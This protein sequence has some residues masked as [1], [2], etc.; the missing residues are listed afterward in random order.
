MDDNK[1]T[2]DGFELSGGAA[3]AGGKGKRAARPF[4]KILSILLT[5]AMI[6][7]TVPGFTM[8]AWAADGGTINLSTVPSGNLTYDDWTFSYATNVYTILDGA[9]VTVTGANAS[10]RRL[11]VAA[12][13]AANI[14]LNGVTITG[15]STSSPLLLNNGAN[16]TLVLADGTTNTLTGGGYYAGIHAPNGT[17][18]TIEG[19]GTL[20]ATGDTDAAGIG[21]SAFNGEEAG[22]I[23]INGGTVIATGGSD[24][25]TG[26]GGAIMSWSNGGTITING[27]TVIAT[28]GGGGR[29]I[30]RGPNGYDGSVTINGGSVKAANNNIQPQPKNGAGDNVYLTTLTVSS[31]PIVDNAAIAAAAISTTPYGVNGVKTDA[32]GKLYFYLPQATTSVDVATGGNLYTNGSI[33]VQNDNATTGVLTANGTATLYSATYNANG[34]TGDVPTAAVEYLAGTQVRVLGNTGGLVK[35]GYVFGGW[36]IAGNGL[37]GVKQADDIFTMPTSAVTL[38]A[39]W[40]PKSANATIDMGDPDPPASGTGWTYSSDIYTILDGANVTVTGTNAGQRRIAVAANATATITLN[41]VSITGLGV[42]QSSLL[43]NS[44]ANVTL[45]LADGTTNTL[46]A[47]GN[48]AGIQAPD[49]TTLLIE[50]STGILNATGSLNSA[51]IGGGLLETGG[52]ITINGGTVTAKSGTDDWSNTGYGGAGIG[53]GASSDASYDPAGAGG[54]IVINGGIVTATGG[55]CRYGGAGIGS[56]G[57]NYMITG[58]AGGNIT[59]NGGTITATGRSYSA[60]IGGG[61]KGEGG[62]I[63]ING[64]SV[65]AT[66]ASSG[67]GIGGG[68]YAAGGNITINGG[69]ITAT[70][71]SGDGAGIGGAQGAAGGTIVITGGIVTAGAVTDVNCI[72]YGY[73]YIDTSGTVTITGGSVKAT[74]N[75]IQPQPKNSESDNVY[76]TTLTVG[77]GTTVDNAA[78]AAAAISTTPYGTN[79][80]KTDA[81]GK[82]Y[83]YLPQ[84]GSTEVAVASGDVR[85]GAASAVDVKADNTGAATLTAGGDATLYAVTYS[86]NSETG[87]NVPV[88]VPASYLSGAQVRVLGNTG[89]LAKT[90][91]VFGGWTL[92]GG[93]TKQPGETFTMPAAAA[94]L[95][96]IWKKVTVT[97]PQT[98]TLTYGTAGSA[99]YAVTT[100][101]I[102]NGTYPVSLTNA[103]GGVSAGN[104][105]ISNNAGTLTLTTGA[106]TAAG[107][108]S[109]IT[110]TIDGAVSEAFTLT[111][112]QKDITATGV[113]ATK[114]YDGTVNFTTDQIN[115]SGAALDGSPANLN[116][117]KTGVTGTLVSANVGNGTL[118]LSGNF[119]LG[120]SAAG[121]YN[122]SAQPDISATITPAD[123]TYSVLGT[124][125]VKV[126]HGLSSIT[127]APS[128][129]TG[130]DGETVAGNV[131]WHTGS[132]SGAA[133]QDSDL[134]SLAVD[135]TVTLYWEF[136]ATATNYTS[137]PKTGST[138]FTVVAKDTQGL[139][140]ASNPLGKTYGDTSFTNIL[141]RSSGDGAITYLSDDE[142]V[143]TVDNSG[144]VTTVGAGTATITATAAETAEFAETSAQ[145]SLAVSKKTLAITGATVDAKT[146]DGTT[147]ATVVSVTF[148]AVEAADSPLTLGTDFTASG[149]FDSADAGNGNKT[150]TVTVV[151]SDANRGK[152]YQI[153]GTYALP[154][155]SIA[156]AEITGFEAINDVSAGY[157]GS[158]TYADAAAVIAALPANVT[159]SWAGGTASV[160]V[161]T[162]TDTDSYDPNADGSYTFTAGL[163]TIPGNFANSGNYTATVEVVI[164]DTYSV[165]VTNGTASPTTAAAGATVTI[166]ADTATSGQQFKNWTTVSSGVTFND[167]NSAITT[168]AMPANPVTVTAN[169]EPIP[170]GTI[171]VS[172]VTL[173]QTSLSLYSNTTPNTA[174]LTAIFAPAN[175]TDKTVTWASGNTAVATVDNNG[176]VTAVGNGTA[177]ITVTTTDGG[178]TAFCTVTV[179]TYTSGSYYPP[180]TPPTDP[181]KPTDPVKPT[182][183]TTNIGGG[184]TVTTPEDKPPVPNPGGGSTLPGG[185]TVNLPDGGTIIVP[186]GTVISGDGKTV[187]IPK[188][189][190]NAEIVHP[191]G[192]RESVQPGYAIDISNPKTPLASLN[193]PFTDVKPGDWFY[194]DVVYV[195]IHG[196]FAGTGGDTFSPNASMT[197]GMIV[198]VLYRLAGEPGTNGG[199]EAFDDVSANSYYAKAVAWAKANGIVS[200]VGGNLFAPD[201]PVTRQDL[202]VILLRYA[203]HTGA[204]LPDTRDYRGFADDA[205]SA[206]YAK[207]AIEAFF[208]AGVIN[209]KGNGMFDPKGTATRAELAAMLHRFIEGTKE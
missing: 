39:I 11:T 114:V 117:V 26:I 63:T 158:A 77:S 134:S 175:A 75:N 179:S 25:C 55:Y 46:T 154:S 42:D 205:D 52:H 35:T 161:A 102:A 62:N 3:K 58:S 194:D 66:G 69:T 115:I 157:A 142:T 78:I 100:E 169:F 191:N 103:P 40:H 174:T 45:N 49:G 111:V 1:F 166:T 96:A 150:V 13:A 38:T 65:I 143:A 197:R 12:N 23:T 162:W 32:N 149:V 108:Y 120:G 28:G 70:S 208:K 73:G 209:G 68:N 203:N 41:G 204:K 6:F 201:K 89:G 144:L 178:F 31:S 29:D 164:A 86:G 48:C 202:T 56:G 59:I 87:G 60:G 97:N 125:N 171:A 182:T 177:V 136:I 170:P 53:G 163:D 199:G 131:T 186:P 159:A 19:T 54:T 81:N 119:T 76:L 118:S 200:G 98:G 176:K 92:S 94:T 8:T 147:D 133:A 67:T 27:G 140:F 148:D 61:N 64:G 36:T 80:V 127:V 14:T 206:N 109:T 95:T 24:G 91:C 110:A 90:D 181:T 156:P 112:G 184:S 168:F 132:S 113:T 167:A 9:N 47:G 84:S 79:G 198:T 33:S 116:L 50:G 180:Y 123:Y 190:D 126:G 121:N 196:L 160:P 135:N 151:F 185:G 153:G 82:L 183:P 16:V 22:T 5:L 72:G 4:K 7:G 104:I 187:T 17:T 88:P 192:R 105:T 173:N 128:D 71:T 188:G 15:L 74:N 101:G 83:F 51:G 172:G 122:L 107:A 138:T 124:Q 37:S 106:T 44:G 10:E 195:Y 139:S 146:Y 57:S 20:N 165:T 34:A 43:L 99:T 2:E 145:Y 141:N 129:G 85:Y 152:N 189:W 155:Q 207:D 193:F 18:L 30:G 137:T 93:G 21:G 130:V